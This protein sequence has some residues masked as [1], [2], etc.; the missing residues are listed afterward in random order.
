MV[1]HKLFSFICHYV[2][3]RQPARIKEPAPPYAAVRLDDMAAGPLTSPVGSSSGGPFRGEVCC[4]CLS[5]LK[6]PG[7]GAEDED[8]DAGVRVLPCM[9]EFHKACIDRWF[10]ACRR[11]CPICRF[12]M[13]GGGGGDGG[14][15]RGGEELTEEMVI[16][17]SSFHAA[18]F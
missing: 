13:E 14:C 8:V 7:A 18:G 6:G 4:V 2:T 11:T 12:S 10:D 17:F 16:W 9:H 15:W 1:V 3:P 5:R